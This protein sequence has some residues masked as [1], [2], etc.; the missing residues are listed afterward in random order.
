[1]KNKWCTFALALALLVSILLPFR[2]ALAVT[3]FRMKGLDATTIRFVILRC[4]SY[5]PVA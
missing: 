5:K 3:T 4:L 1:M 2:Q